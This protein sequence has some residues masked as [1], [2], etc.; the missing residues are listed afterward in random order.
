MRLTRVR[1]LTEGMVLASD[2][3]DSTGR[4]LLLEG[5]ELKDTFINKL[6][7]LGIFAVYVYDSDLYPPKTSIIPLSKEEVVTETEKALHDITLK[8]NIKAS[9]LREKVANLIKE[10]LKAHTLAI[11]VA[12]LQSYDRYTLDHS[13]NVAVLSII[14]GLSYGFSN[15]ELV[16]LGIGALLH[17]VGKI[18]V[19][20]EILTKKGK[21]T[22]SEWEEIKEHP[23]YGYKLLARNMDISEAALKVVK[24]HH[25]R[26]NGTGYPH[27]LRGESLSPY[28][29]I[30]MI[31]DAFDAMTSNRV[32]KKGV[33]PYEAI[34]VVKAMRG[35]LFDN[36]I[37][38]AFLTNMVAYPIGC[39]VRL[40]NG[41]IGVV[42]AT[43]DNTESKPTVVLLFDQN[44]SMYKDTK[45]V[46]LAKEKGLAVVGTV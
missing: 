26:I 15:D 29:K 7:Q 46:S 9:A 14:T 36:E 23:T 12:E 19:S 13:F 32:Y 22:P 43:D 44:G 41:Q 27:G 39:R 35:L 30:A 2:V 18:F 24:E 33:T 17:D 11:F 45:T 8:K 10:I 34:K 31:S 1:E 28:G 3:L 42:V 4:I 20:K 37:T 6:K 16:E 38:E 25:E 40:N 21:L 5:I